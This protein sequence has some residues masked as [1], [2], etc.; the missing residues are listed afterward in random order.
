[1]GRGR[2]LA[3]EVQLN[4]VINPFQLAGALS[5]K[6]QQLQRERFKK[7]FWAVLAAHV[8]LFLSLLIQ[9]CRSGQQSVSETQ[10]SG[11]VASQNY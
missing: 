5:G 9:G 11:T 10:N 1:M 2:A 7:I 8:L 3:R 6:P 4:D